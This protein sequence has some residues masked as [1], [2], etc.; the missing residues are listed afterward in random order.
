LRHNLA[1][2]VQLV[3]GCKLF[4]AEGCFFKKNWDLASK[5][6]NMTISYFYEYKPIVETLNQA[7]EKIRKAKKLFDKGITLIRSL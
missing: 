2:L 4:A 5:H 3:F 7:A 6:I 1:A